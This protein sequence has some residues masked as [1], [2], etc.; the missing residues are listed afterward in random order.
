[1]VV[2]DSGGK[3]SLVCREIVRRAGVP[4]EVVHHLTTEDAPE[5]V[6]YVRDSFKKLEEQG[7][8]CRIDKPF[9]GKRPVTMWSLIP[10]KKFPPTRIQRYCCQVLK[11]N[12]IRDRFIITGV[13]WAESIKRRNQRGI[14][15]NFTRNIKQKLILNNDNDEKRLLFETCTLKGKRVCNPI[16]DWQDRDVWDYIRSE[17]LAFN[18]LYEKGFFRVGCLGCPMAGRRR[19][20]EFRLYPTYR[21]AYIRAFDKMLENLKQERSSV[22]WR[23]GIEV[24]D[25]WMEDDTLEGQIALS[26]LESWRDSNEEGI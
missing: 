18:P 3:D 14:F 20:Q 8:C 22:R 21:R 13:R 15:E 1:M 6:Y 9:Y 23:N 19:C 11:E 10:I 12:M 26:D 2:T 4:Y 7:I 24:F 5:T 16:I 17:H 25:W